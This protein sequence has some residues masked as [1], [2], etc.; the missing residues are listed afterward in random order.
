MVTYAQR[1]EDLLG[2]G[3]IIAQ[4][5]A[6]LSPEAEGAAAAFDFAQS[7][8]LTRM[9]ESASGRELI[10]AGFSDDVELAAALETSDSVPTLH[11]GAF[12][13]RPQRES[14]QAQ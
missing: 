14:D 7:D 11:E 13:D 3:A 1:V 9:R 5:D 6:R 2:A 10:A 4:L 8:L 12:A